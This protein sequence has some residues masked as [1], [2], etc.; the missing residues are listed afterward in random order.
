MG[1]IRM[2]KKEQSVMVATKYL[3]VVEENMELLI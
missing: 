3:C 1:W 2:G